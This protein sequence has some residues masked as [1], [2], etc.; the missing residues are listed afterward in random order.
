M[1]EIWKDIPGFEG[2]YQ[3][4]N[5][6]NIRSVRR[7]VRFGSQ[8]RVVKQSNLRLFKK[9]NGY[10]HVKIYKDGK[11]YTMYVHRLV[12]IAFCSGYF[13][14][15]DVNHKDGRK[16]NNIYSNLEWCTRSE[17]QIHSVKVLHNNL[18]NRKI[19]KK[20]NSKPIVQLSIDGKKIK[21]WT[22]AFEVQRVLG[23]SESA[24]R[25]CLYGDNQ[26][27]RRCYQSYGYKWVYAKD[28]YK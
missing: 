19:C 6:G 18:G 28:Y 21:D 10:L 27:G 23:I 2:L 20:W 17:N 8:Q 26:K 12:A 13:D 9:A 11:Q 25:K 14:K 24:I 16:D 4:S 22:S 5:I 15:A 3:V 1:D 7:V